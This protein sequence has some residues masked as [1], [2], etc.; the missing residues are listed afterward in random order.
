MHEVVVPKIGQG[1]TE[2]EILEWKVAVGERVAAGQPLLEVETEKLTTELEADAAGVVA[3]LLAEVGDVV[4]VGSA[5]CR[6]E[7]EEAGG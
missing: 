5:I 2:V 6:I 3:E 7:A 4:E 1:T